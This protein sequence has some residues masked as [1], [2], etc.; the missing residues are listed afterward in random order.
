MK[1]IIACII[2]MAAFFS[3]LQA[4]AFADAW[5]GEKIDLDD[6]CYLIA[7]DVTVIATRASG[8]VSGKKPYTC[9]DSDGTALWKVEL[10]GSFTYNG[11][12]ATCTASSIST[13]I[14]DSTWSV[15][16]KSAQKSGRQAIG[17]VTMN[18]RS[19]GVTIK[20]V[21]VSLSISCS[22]NGNLS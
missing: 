5:N 8:S 17:S 9:Y 13:T 14:F 19:A 6:G 11:T 20:S 10:S 2:T 3:I 18:K 4:G 16:A 22:E 15:G 21:P 12:M 7:G 1:R